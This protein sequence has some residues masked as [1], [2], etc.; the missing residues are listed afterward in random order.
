MRPISIVIFLLLLNMV[1]IAQKDTVRKYLD[2]ELHFTTKSKGVFPALVIKNGDRWLLVAVYPDTNMLL[3]LYFKDAAL[4]IKDGPFVL[5]HPKGIKSE[6]GHFTNNLTDGL[7]Q[8]WYK[9][10]HLRDSGSFNKNHYTGVWKHWYQSGGLATQQDFGT[11]TNTDQNNDEPINKTGFLDDIHPRGTKNGAHYTWY[12]DG[13][14]E[15]A[16]TYRNDSLH[17]EWLWYRQDGTISSKEIYAGGKVVDLACYNEKGG[18]T[19][20]TC[21]ILKYPLLIHPFLTARDYILDQLFRSKFRDIKNDGDIVISFT[22]AKD[23]KIV[24]LTIKSSPDTALSKHI[25]DIFA[26]MPPWSPAVSH[27]RPI[28]FPIEFTLPFYR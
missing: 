5:Y 14:K 22:V 12:E 19:G 21:S 24:N 4:T 11:T 10:G 23:G 3:R 17:G 16:G 28:D 9:D 7:W 26:T 2:A 8:T 25:M 15:A 1:S 20:A 13:T 6:E 27:N 18:Y